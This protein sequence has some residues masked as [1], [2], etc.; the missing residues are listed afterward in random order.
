[1]GEGYD[2]DADEACQSGLEEEEGLVAGGG[3]GQRVVVM[4]GEGGDWVSSSM[5]VVTGWC[6]SAGPAAS[7]APGCP[8][9]NSVLCAALC[10][11]DKFMSHHPLR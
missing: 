2:Q 10:R 8:A 5:Q 6:S 11:S 4:F 3:D 9:L 7:L 1:M